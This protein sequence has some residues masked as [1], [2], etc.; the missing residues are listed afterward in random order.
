M[1]C[2]KRPRWALLLGIAAAAGAQS[3][4]VL[5]SA[6]SRGGSSTILIRVISPAGKEPAA[7]QW[8][9]RF[10]AGVSAVPGEIAAGSAAVSAQK[11]ITCSANPEVTCTCILAGGEKP[12]RNGTIAVI[13]YK[14]S[15]GT[16]K[17]TI[18]V[19]VQK[20]LGVTADSR[21]IPIPDT[22][23]PITVR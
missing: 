12:I 22:E 5:P 6:V 11:T 1:R 3:L 16:R 13:P 20:A 7:L 19:S 10:P 21:P 4:E 15:T 18:R 17:G 23:G 14:I 9:L 2:A 8:N